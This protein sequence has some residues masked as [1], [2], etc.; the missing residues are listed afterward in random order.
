MNPTSAKRLYRGAAR[1]DAIDPRHRG[2]AYGD[3]LFET[4]RVHAGRVHWWDRH[5]LR[6]AQGAARLGIVVPDALYVQ[7]Q[8]QGMVH[9]Q[10]DG[11]LKL[12]LSRGVGGRGYAPSLD[13]ES[14]WQLSLHPLPVAPPAQ[15]LVLRWCHTTLAYQPLLAGLKHCNRLEQVLARGEW[16]QRGAHDIDADEG[17]MCDRDGNIVSAIAA[18]LFALR[19]GRWCT[20][21]LDGSGVAGI[22]RGW[23]LQALDAVETRIARADLA[24]A[25][26]VF[27]CNAV[28]GILP[29]ARLGDREWPPSAAIASAQRKLAAAHPAMNKLS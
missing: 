5:W 25:D 1:I 20:P 17:L 9:G 26:A 23:A 18:N 29:V 16:Q 12:I 15:G 8:V 21:L 14:D 11:V 2:I 10:G 19:D 28:R 24:A 22:C 6:L 27:L 4:M 13:A 3:G 7:A